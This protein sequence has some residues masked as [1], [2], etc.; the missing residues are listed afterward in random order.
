[1]RHV[2]DLSLAVVASDTGIYES[3]DHEP[4]YY[5]YIAMHLSLIFCHTLWQILNRIDESPDVDDA[6][7][8][9][10]IGGAGAKKAGGDCCK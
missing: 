5:V 2:A 1:V 9:V 4:R 3:I 6:G 10:R 7:K 8:G